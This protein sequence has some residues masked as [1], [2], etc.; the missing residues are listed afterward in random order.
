[1]D[2]PTYI[3]RFPSVLKKAEVRNRS[4]RRMTLSM[5]STTRR[6]FRG[7][8][9]KFFANSP[10]E[11]KAR[12]ALRDLITEKEWRRYAIYGFIMV[13]GASGWWYQISAD[14]THTVVREKGE[15][16]GEICIVTDKA[17]PPTDHVLTI[18]ALID[19][20]EQAAWDGAN[21]YGKELQLQDV[22]E[23]FNGYLDGVRAARYEGSLEYDLDQY[24]EL[25][26]SIQRA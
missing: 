4:L 9:M 12:Q 22:I 19:L 14:R 16:V 8:H 10:Q 21:V 24:Y 3:R 26:E 18:K 13:Q 6:P 11:L 25:S 7:A 2:V 23:E 20:D 15:R 17:C 5:N 1:M